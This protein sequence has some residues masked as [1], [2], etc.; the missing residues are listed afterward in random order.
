MLLVVTTLPDVSVGANPP[1]LRTTALEECL[2][3]LF[4]LVNKQFPEIQQFLW[5]YFTSVLILQLNE[6]KIKYIFIV[7]HH[8][9]H[10][11]LVIK[12]TMYL[13]L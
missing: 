3:N 1:Q 13:F 5:Y 8:T 7:K 12:V 9:G 10:E 4:L 6:S 11:H 2:R